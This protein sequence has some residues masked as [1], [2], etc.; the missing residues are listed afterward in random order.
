M[1]TPIVNIY[2]PIA[3]GD[4]IVIGAGNYNATYGLLSRIEN[5]IQIQTRDLQ[6]AEVLEFIVDI[7]GSKFELSLLHAGSDPAQYLN[8]TLHS[9]DGVPRATVTL[10]PH[11]A[12]FRISYSNVDSNPRRNL[13][14]GTLYALET[15]LGDQNLEV[16]WPI[17]DLPPGNLVTFL[18]SSWYEIKESICSFETGMS[19]LLPRLQ[20]LQFKGFSTE[21]WCQ[22]LSH[23]IN[24]DGE[25]ICGECMGPCP[26]PNHI[27]YKDETTHQFKCGPAAAEPQFLSSNITLAQAS[28]PPTTTGDVA[29]V[30][31]V[32]IV[33]LIIGLLAWGLMNN[34]S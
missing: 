9:D 23:V 17:Q 1:D 8:V 29:T 34:T 22:E 3:N 11:R 33:L 15:T 7:A 2:G 32:L 24:C 25:S 13:L 16:W 28:E 21:Q 10:S 31:A 26:N 27:C 4:R 14:A 19:S 12:Y 20:Q 6:P 18:P 30:I 5:G